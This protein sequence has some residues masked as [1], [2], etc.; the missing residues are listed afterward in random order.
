MG[1]EMVEV[2]I[3]SPVD[4]TVYRKL[5]VT[6]DAQADA[7]L[8]HTQSAQKDWARTSLKKRLEICKGFVQALID[9]TET[10]SKDL[11]WQMGRPIDFS[12]KEIA[13]VV[14]RCEAMFSAARQGLKAHVLAEHPN[15]RRIERVPHGVVLVIAPWNYPFLT[16]INTIMPA[17]LA[18]NTVILKPAAQTALTGQQ[19]ADAFAK[20]GLPEGVFSNL[21]LSHETIARWLSNRKVDFASFTGSV[22]G[23][24]QIEKAA[25]GKF[26]PIS[27]ELGGK[28]P[29]YV[30]ADTNI[31]YAARELVDGSFFNSGQSCCGIERIYV[32]RQIYKQFVDCFVDITDET[33]KVGDPLLPGTT[34]GPLVSTEAANDIRTQINKAIANGAGVLRGDTKDASDSAYMEATILVDVD[35]SMEIMTEETFGPV[36]GIMPVDGDAAAIGLMNDSKYGLSA[37]IW[38]QDLTAAEA[39]GHQIQTGTL[40]VNRCDYLDPQLA[41]VGVKDSGKGCS[42]SELGFHHVTRPKSYNIKN[43]L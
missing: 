19:F 10:I 33:Q 7:S 38:S 11:T 18:G 43:Q 14:E 8:T 5:P 30:R 2:S 3:I 41:W 39:V 34:L 40:F 29:A 37:S 23:G 42:L 9:N 24:G 25:V 12:P 22:R 27:L 6:T 21:L 16:A 35:H 1:Q 15:S 13:G 32:D 31:E 36:V 20:A 28:D 26:L 4:G 17:L